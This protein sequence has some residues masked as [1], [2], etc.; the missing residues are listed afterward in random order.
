MASH[1]RI[2]AR[3]VPPALTAAATAVALAAGLLGAAAGTGNAT[4]RSVSGTDSGIDSVPTGIRTVSSGWTVPWGLSWLPDGSALL[5]ERDSF[6]LFKLTQSGTRTQVGT[7]P[8]VVTTNG[9]G[10]L[11]GV[12]VSP[13]W[14]TDHYVY[15]MHS[16][17]SDNRIVRMT[18]DGSSLSGYKVLVT[19]IAKNKY[20][21]G[22][23]IKFGPDGYLYATTGDAQNG[24][25]AQDKNSLNG[26]ILRMTADGKPA[27]GN[28]FGT[29]VFS[30]GHRNPQGLTWDAQGRLWEAEFGNSKYDEL[31]LIESGKNYGWPIC[32]GTCS[33]SGMTNPKRQWTVSEASPSAVAYAD[34]ALYLA[35]LRGERLW[36]IP[37]SGTSAGT[38]VAHYTS[39]YGRLRTVEKVPG[40]NALWLSTT[41]A[42]NNGGEPDGADKVFQV[43]LG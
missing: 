4:A 24:D 7:V 19:G 3:R 6:K 2:T 9:E 12:A 42:D 20:H 1:P 26:K 40:K 15:L 29:L 13:N 30:L 14:R 27:P 22:G 11:L 25:R 37:V 38:P 36:R 5:T 34:G 33:S 21:N 41:N 39:Q 43:D 32:E 17:A 31:N 28:P 23:R 16:A 8:N 35:A 18:Y 10:G